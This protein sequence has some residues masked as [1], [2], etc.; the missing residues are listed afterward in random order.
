MIEVISDLTDPNFGDVN[1]VL[2]GS[3]GN[4]IQDT[5]A[6]DVADPGFDGQHCANWNSAGQV[7]LFDNNVGGSNAVVMDIDLIGQTAAT[8]ESWPMGLNCNIQ[9]SMYEMAGGG[10][11]ATCADRGVI[12]A[13]ETGNPNATWTLEPSCGGG[14]GPP[15]L[16]RAVP[17]VLD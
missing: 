14:G 13:F 4:P 5:I 11:I 9:G 1:W 2:T 6:L 7:I 15:A 17:L 10:Y 3:A 12:M 8:A 16:M